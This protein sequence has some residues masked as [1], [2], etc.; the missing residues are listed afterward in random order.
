MALT[1]VKELVRHNAN[2]ELSKWRAIIEYDGASYFVVGKFNEGFDGPRIVEWWP[3]DEVPASEMRGHIP[4]ES[5]LEEFEPEIQKVLAGDLPVLDVKVDNNNVHNN[6]VDFSRDHVDV[7]I[8]ERKDDGNERQF[9][10]MAT[11]RSQDPTHFVAKLVD[12]RLVAFRKTADHKSETTIKVDLRTEPVLTSHLLRY[13]VYTFN[14]T[15][16]AAELYLD[17]Q[18]TLSGCDTISEC[19]LS[20]LS[21]DSF[22]EAINEKLNELIVWLNDETDSDELKEAIQIFSS[23]KEEG[24]DK[25]QEAL[26]EA[27][28]GVVADTAVW[29]MLMAKYPESQE[30]LRRRRLEYWSECLVEAVPADPFEDD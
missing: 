5:H 27:T 10:L 11:F 18:F 14:H 23:N 25:R 6:D 13:W 21:G 2:N 4:E 24:M 26:S 1:A 19:N 20:Q 12:D 29:K 7:T 30:Q 15:S 3:A 17:E 9:K 22:A 8:F 16:D 28:D